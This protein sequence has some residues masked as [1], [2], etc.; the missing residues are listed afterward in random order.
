MS[1]GE[2]I[3]LGLFTFFCGGYMLYL[4]TLVD[5]YEDDLRVKL[6]LKPRN[7]NLPRGPMAWRFPQMS[8]PLLLGLFLC[9]MGAVFIGLGAG[10][11]GWIIIP[12]LMSITSFLVNRV[13]T[14][15]WGGYR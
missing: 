14:N 10:L 7:T 12:V 8:V 2:L 6:G 11:W 5:N 3:W 9:L 13:K 4:A 15:E 1:N